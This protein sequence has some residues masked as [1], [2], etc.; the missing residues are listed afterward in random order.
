VKLA[1]LRK[2]RRLQGADLW[3]LVAAQ[4]ELVRASVAVRT[5]PTGQLVSPASAPAAGGAVR[6]TPGGAG[7][8]ARIDTARRLALAVARAAENGVLRPT[9]LV[10]SV[11]LQ[12]MLERRGLSGSRI[13]IG[14]RMHEGEF[15]AHAW[16]EW[17]GEILGDSRWHVDRFSPLVDVGLASRS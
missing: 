5:R 11:A 8:D 9:C 6:T 4:W 3:L 12:R 13:H 7:P 17:S 1:S 16:V 2:L 15:L 14:V 10:R